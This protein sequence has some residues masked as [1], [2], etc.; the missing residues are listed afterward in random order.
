[1]IRNIQNLRKLSKWEIREYARSIT[2]IL[3]SHE[4]DGQRDARIVDAIVS[5]AMKGSRSWLKRGSALQG[6]IGPRMSVL[7]GYLIYPT[8]G[9]QPVTIQSTTLENSYLVLDIVGAGGGGGGGGG[10]NTTASTTYGQG[11]GGGGDGGRLIVRTQGPLVSGTQ[12]TAQLGGTGGSGGPANSAG[13]A[14]SAPQ[15]N[16]QVVLG[17]GSLTISVAG[18][19]APTMPPTAGGQNAGGAGGAGGSAVFTYLPTT[20]IFSAIQLNP[21]TSFLANYSG[22][23]DQGIGGDGVGSEYFTPSNT[24]PIFVSTPQGVRVA[25]GNPGA[26]GTSATANVPT[27][28]I[29]LRGSGA[30]GGGGTNNATSPTAGGNGGSGGPG[31]IILLVI[32]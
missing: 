28:A 15:G 19:S 12:F 25:G 20:P 10:G 9:I 17:N 30:G 32:G 16:T 24:T 29:A 8:S 2:P 4:I 18:A 27:G 13:G 6:F 31:P 1:M 5:Y 11:G 14:G 7:E 21:R 3:E 26:A 23:L 22:V